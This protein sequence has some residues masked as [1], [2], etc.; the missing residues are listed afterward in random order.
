MTLVA[1]SLHLAA[2]CRHGMPPQE[3]FGHHLAAFRLVSARCDDGVEAAANLFR[4]RRM[5][6]RRSGIAADLQTFLANEPEATRPDTLPPFPVYDGVVLARALGRIA[7][8]ALAVPD[9]DATAHEDLAVVMVRYMTWQVPK[10][11]RSD[12]ERAFATRIGAEFAKKRL[13]KPRALARALLSATVAPSDLDR[14]FDP[15][16]QIDSSLARDDRRGCGRRS[17]VDAAQD[18]AGVSGDAT[19]KEVRVV[20]D[21]FEQRARYALSTISAGLLEYSTQVLADG[22]EP[23]ETARGFI[24]IFLLPVPDSVTTPPKNRARTERVRR[25]LVERVV[26]ALQPSA[27]QQRPAGSAT[28]SKPL[29]TRANRPWALVRVLLSAVCVSDTTI[30]SILEGGRVSKS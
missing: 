25:K 4:R 16:T 6:R 26:A 24:R 2:E 12:D 10:Y 30:E 9:F 20:V 27:R 5:W 14:V 17:I 15:F 23:A 28:P 7:A 8:M 18:A 22:A 3:E 1:A 29:V 21:R 11:L 19:E 13:D